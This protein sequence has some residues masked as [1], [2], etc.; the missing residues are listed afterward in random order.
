MFTPGPLVVALPLGVETPEPFAP[1]AVLELELAPP[2]VPLPLP[3]PLALPP[4]PLP[5][6]P[7]PPDCANA[8][9]VKPNASVA[10]T[11][12]ALIPRMPIS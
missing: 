3:P 9:L 10:A 5:P 11:A 7:P 1:A 4:P 12:I 6:P 8:R 2:V